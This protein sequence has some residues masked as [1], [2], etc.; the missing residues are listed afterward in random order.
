MSKDQPPRIAPR[1]AEEWR[2]WLAEHHASAGAVWL[3]FYK[4]HADRPSP[5][6][7]EVVDEALC[8][9]WVDSK[10]RRIDDDRYELYL[11][12]R[13]PG[14]VWSRI[15]KDK[16]ERLIAEGRMT[17]AGLALVESAKVDGSWS[18]LEPAERGEIP[19]ALEAAFD[20]LPGSREGFGQL[21]ES[22]RRRCLEQI[23]LAKRPATKQ[24]RA[25]QIAGWALAGEV[26][27]M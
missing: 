19:P 9:G 15:N 2:A 12:P 8:F 26:P 16:V 24:R 7:G 3:I 13:K 10:V 1:D 5:S 22:V 20:T 11:S 25:E 14:S 27:G 21:S 23:L 4:K 17:P 18:L 6:L